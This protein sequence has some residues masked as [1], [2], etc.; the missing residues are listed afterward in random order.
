MDQDTTGEL[1]R[2][3]LLKRGAG[4][5]TAGAVGAAASSTAS[6]QSD[7]YGGYLSETDNFEGQTADA[8]G[9]DEVTVTVGAGT[10]GL[11]FDPPALLIEPGTT[12][13]FEWTGNGGAHNVYHDTAVAD[14]EESLFDSGEPVNDSGVLYEFTFESSNTGTFPYA[15]SPHRGLG[16][17]G[18][19]V[20]G[21]ENVQGDTTPFGAAEETLNS[22]AIFGG[23]AVFGTTAL[24]G[25]SAYREMFGDDEQEH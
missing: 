23:A 20:V 4:A 16:M 1:T 8:T 15:C 24:V 5:A 9:M 14:A 25:L 3:S 7:L 10:S 12:V 21:E 19:I 6:A 22:V 18:V 17:R 11:L 13:N 2:R